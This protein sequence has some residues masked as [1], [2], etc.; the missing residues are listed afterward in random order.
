MISG[1]LSLWLDAYESSHPP[2]FCDHGECS[3]RPALDSR[4][5][6]FV[7][8]GDEGAA[9]DYLCKQHAREIAEEWADR[10]GEEWYL[11][12]ACQAM[13]LRHVFKL[14]RE[15]LNTSRKGNA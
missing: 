15:R 3:R 2:V 9:P 11:V 6:G 5:E 8:F 12:P 7:L 14:E 13:A 10:L 4:T 1:E